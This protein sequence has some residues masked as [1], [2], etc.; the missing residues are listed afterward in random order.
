MKLILN[1]RFLVF[2]TGI[3]LIRAGWFASLP[4]MAIYLLKVFQCNPIEIGAIIGAGSFACCVTGVF[5]GSLADKYGNKPVIVFSILLSAIVFLLFSLSSQLI[6]FGVLNIFLGVFRSFFDAA[7]KSYIVDIV[8]IAMRGRAFGWRYAA[9][10]VGAIIGPP[11]A[12]L[13]FFVSPRLIFLATAGCYFV[14]SLGYFFAIKAY[15]SNNP[16]MCY[17][18]NIKSTFKVISKQKSVLYLVVVGVTIYFALSQLDTTLPQIMALRLNNYLFLYSAFLVTNAL[19]VIT[20]QVPLDILRK[21]I[22]NKRFVYFSVSTYALAFFLLSFVNMSYILFL[23]VVF[24]SIGEVANITLNNIL[25]DEYSPTHMKGAYF[26]LAN[27]SML[28]LFLGPLLGG[29]LLK[30]TNPV[31]L[32]LTT[33]V[34][35]ISSLYFHK[36][37]REC[38]TKQKRLPQLEYNGLQ[39][40]DRN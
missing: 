24:L 31:V 22:G 19:I 1:S 29:V 39:K 18:E 12:V 21:H 11:I 33:S 36:L 40:V 34:V 37:S 32:Y 26:G 6:F 4:F 35:I 38:A 13:V 20:F 10:N 5:G 25:M 7:S 30:Y 28:G 17:F 9:I 15:P 23:G 2:L 3:V 27:F 14:A 16:D 8:P